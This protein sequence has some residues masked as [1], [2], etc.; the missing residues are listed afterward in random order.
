MANKRARPSPALVLHVLKH[1]GV[2][3][4][5]HR[6]VGVAEHFGHR[7]ERDALPQ[8]QG[9]GGVAQVVEANLY[10]VVGLLVES[11]A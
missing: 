3:P 10:R 2:A 7:V 9:A 11:T 1:V 5:R 4:E 6:Q 8:S